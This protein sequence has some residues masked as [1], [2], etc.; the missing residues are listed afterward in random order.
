MGHI[1]TNPTFF[2]AQTNSSVIA[3]GMVSCY[4]PIRQGTYFKHILLLYKTRQM[5]KTQ[6]VNLWN[7]V[8]QGAQL[9]TIFSVLVIGNDLIFYS[10]FILI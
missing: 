2:I 7:F 1:S 10:V 3:I 8:R 9:M 5:D 6:M 4:N